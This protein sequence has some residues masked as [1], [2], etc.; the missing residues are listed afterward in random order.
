MHSFLHRIAAV[1]QVG[2]EG[3]LVVPLAREEDPGGLVHGVDVEL[4]GAL[5]LAR[6][7]PMNPKDVTDFSHDR[8]VFEPL[9]VDDDEG[10]AE[11]F[12]DFVA[13]RATVLVDH[14]QGGYVLACTRLVRIRRVN[15]HC[16]QV[17]LVLFFLWLRRQAGVV[18]LLALGSLFYCVFYSCHHQFLLR[19]F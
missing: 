2:V 15:D 11:L 12:E 10:V 5:V 6:S 9:G 17:H 1:A 4:T 19:K 18:G 7:R 14:F 13:L 16:V 3:G 8:A